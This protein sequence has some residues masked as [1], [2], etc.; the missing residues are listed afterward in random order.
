M[1][2]VEQL[3]AGYGPLQVLHDINFEV[4]AHSVVAILGV[5]G[6]GKTTL[7]RALSGLI[8]LRSGSITLGEQRIDQLT[9]EQRVRHGMALVP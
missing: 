7:M 1:L 6:A 4:P 9:T 2:R 3:C 5:N 8:R